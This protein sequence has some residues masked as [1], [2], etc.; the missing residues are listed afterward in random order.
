MKGLLGYGR[1]EDDPDHV[2]CP[3]ASSDMTPCVARDGSCACDSD[4]LCVGCGAHPGDL[5]EAAALKLSSVTPGAGQI[6]AE[7]S[8]QVLD[9]K[10]DSD[11][12][13]RYAEGELV[14]AAICYA[15]HPDVI[16]DSDID[17]PPNDLWPW[18]PEW[19]KPT[20]RIRDLAKAGA[21]IA[22]EMDRLL[23]RETI[24]G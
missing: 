9:E 22:A 7:R 4:G 13:A 10:F 23:A 18:A 24:D 19:W 2:G 12:D 11:R 21:L 20:D 1:Y 5:L 6:A 16:I 8:R 15:G 14:R 17:P 3:R